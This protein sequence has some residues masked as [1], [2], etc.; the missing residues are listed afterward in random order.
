MVDQTQEEILEVQTKNKQ[1]KYEADTVN[2]FEDWIKKCP[3]KFYLNE[4]L[5]DDFIKVQYTFTKT[6]RIE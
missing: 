2:L 5:D 6:E 3:V 1:I 4:S